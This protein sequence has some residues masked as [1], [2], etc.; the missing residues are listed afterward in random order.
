MIQNLRET[1]FKIE[2]FEESFG[3]LV[4]LWKFCYDIE[5]S[6]NK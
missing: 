6:F 5:F 2:D 4:A 1:L 3:E